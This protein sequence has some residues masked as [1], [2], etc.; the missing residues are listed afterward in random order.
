MLKNKDFK[1]CPRSG[2]NDWIIVEGGKVRMISFKE[3]ARLGLGYHIAKF[4]SSGKFSMGKA[5]WAEVHRV[6]L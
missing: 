1:E 5:Y 4:T 6:A 2:N 3:K